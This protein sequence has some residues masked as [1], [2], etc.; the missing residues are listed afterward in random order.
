M[1]KLEP[2]IRKIFFYGAFVLLIIAA[3]EKAVNLL[4]RKSLLAPYWVAGDLIEFAAVALIF[5]IAMQ[6]HQI[7]LLL[8]KPK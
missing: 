1:E 6:L 5:C 2:V 8:S 7:R 3:V 4:M